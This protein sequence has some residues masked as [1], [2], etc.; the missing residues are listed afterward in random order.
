VSPIFSADFV[1]VGGELER[2]DLDLALLRI[3]PMSDLI[4]CRGI[5][6]RKSSDALP[7]QQTYH[8]YMSCDADDLEYP[9]ADNQ[10]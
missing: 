2:R 4:G 10:F 7:P 3:W 9:V 5:L 1:V 8:S 6:S